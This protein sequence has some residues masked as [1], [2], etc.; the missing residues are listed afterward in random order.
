MTAAAS[1]LCREPQSPRACTQPPLQMPKSLWPDGPAAWSRSPVGAERRAWRQFATPAPLPCG[2]R[3]AV[4]IGTRAATSESTAGSGG[5]GA[6]CGC[7]SRGQ[8]LNL[9]LLVLLALLSRPSLKLN[10]PQHGS[11]A[12]YSASAVVRGSRK[13]G[14]K[15]EGARGERQGCKCGGAHQM[16]AVLC[17]KMYRDQRA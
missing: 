6:C 3:G 16:A 4:P 5:S 2:Q 13:L 17:V 1:H 12:G 9:A 11:S 7:G 10:I 14:E 15:S 8:P